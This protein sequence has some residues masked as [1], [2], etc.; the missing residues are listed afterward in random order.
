[1]NILVTGVCGS[2]MRAVVPRLLEAGHTVRGVDNMLRYGPQ[3]P[4]EG[5]E[6]IAG[7]L[8]EASVVKDVMRDVD[9]VVQA[10][11]QI[12]GVAG[13]HRHPA[14]ILQ[15]DTL[16]HGLIL[17]EAVERGVNRVVYISSSMVYE[18]H[19]DV[20]REA[21]VPNMLVPLTDYGLSKLMGERL[22]RAFFV[23]YGL[24]YTI[25]RPFN[26]I[27]LHESAQGYD[28]GVCHV[29]ADFIHRV[30][31]EHQNP[32]LILGSGE[33]V[34]CFTWIDD[35]ATAIADLSFSPQ[36]ENEDFNLGNP[37]PISMLELAARIFALYHQM[38]GWESA[39]PL[40]F[41]HAPT[42]SD[43]V[44][45]RIPS[46]DKAVDRLGWRPTMMLDEMLRRC[47]AFAMHGE[48]TLTGSSSQRVG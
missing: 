9:G 13:F 22:S 7:D 12:F 11:A 42:Y 44:Q 25:W 17:R 46:I 36:T 19:P 20:A 39:D 6:F 3:E 24:H 30:V 32:M 48:G 29:F 5:I 37:E 14:D 10:A 23:Q 4:P 41:T 18:R 26:I 1:M 15:R 38:S 28:P 2:L 47:I 16:L 43:D 27:G 35:V 40:A 33:Q 21:D 31:L 34:R 45:I 8:T